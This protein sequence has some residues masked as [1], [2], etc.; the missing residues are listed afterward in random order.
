MIQTKPTEKLTG[1]TIQ[2]DYDDF[3][4]LTEAFHNAA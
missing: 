2:G 1:V 3:Y 4:Q